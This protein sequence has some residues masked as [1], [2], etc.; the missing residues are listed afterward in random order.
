MKTACLL[1]FCEVKTEDLAVIAP[2]FEDRN[3]V[4]ADHSALYL[5][6]WGGFLGTEYAIS[7]D[8]L[9]LRRNNKHGVS[10]YPPLVKGKGKLCDAVKALSCL[11][12]E[13]V[14][15]SAVPAH[16]VE[17]IEKCLHVVE[18]STSRRWADYI[19]NA[20][21]LATLGGNRYH[22]KRNLVH[23]FERLYEDRAYEDITG[24][25]LAEVVDFMH[26]FMAQ[27]EMSE[28]KRFEN[29][30]V[31]ALL[32][33]YDRLPVIGGLVRVG[34]EVAA[35]TLAE[36]ID[37]TLLVHVEK[38]DR[39]FKGAYQYINCR[40][41]REQLAKRRFTLVNREDDSGDEG[42]RQAKLSYNPIDILHKYR[43]IVQF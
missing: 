26:R 8:V 3:T 10:Y 1:R 37:D 9:F 27:G 5:H 14:A 38:A 6:M 42:L 35:F 4:I 32:S 2:Y 16:A 13:R 24:E 12:E 23:Q 18:K 17:E 41:V 34:G 25:N 15:L 43:M 36:H 30:R 20:A 11:G 28:D 31:L 33:E 22:K 7:D 40:F 21:D 29:E 39:R 19:Y